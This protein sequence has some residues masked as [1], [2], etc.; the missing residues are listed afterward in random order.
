MRHVFVFSC[1]AGIILSIAVYCVRLVVIRTDEAT[2][3]AVLLRHQTGEIRFVNSVTGG[4]VEIGFSVLD[5]FRNFSI[6]TDPVTEAYYSH[7]VY[8]LDRAIAGEVQTK[9]NFCSMKGI[10]LR[11]GFSTY[12]IQNSCL[13]A[14]LLWTM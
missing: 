4:S 8:D 10:V 14:E 6:R 3:L 1:L 5:R 9:L 12:K 2:H 11:L 13:E 7:G